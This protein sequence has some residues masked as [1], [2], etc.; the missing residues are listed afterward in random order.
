MNLAGG[1]VNPFESRERKKERKKHFQAREFCYEQFSWSAQRKKKLVSLYSEREITHFDFSFPPTRER[2]PVDA[3]LRNK[4]SYREAL[5]RN[6]HLLL[7][8]LERRNTGLT[9]ETEA[10]VGFLIKL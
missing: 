1:K 2:P 7:F 10:S 5:R 8:K 4:E 6:C 3:D 9:S